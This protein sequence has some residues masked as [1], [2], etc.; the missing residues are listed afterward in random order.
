MGEVPNEVPL[1]DI[2]LWLQIYKLPYDTFS[3]AMGRS[4]GNYIGKFLEYD[5]PWKKFMRVRVELDINKSLKKGRKINVGGT[6]NSVDFKYEHLH[7]FCYICG[8]LGHTEQFYEIL[9]MDIKAADWRN[10]SLGREKAGEGKHAT[11]E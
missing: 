3:E 2:A 5:T 10:K 8:N 6:S 11:R 4:L 7:I 9:Q 1:N